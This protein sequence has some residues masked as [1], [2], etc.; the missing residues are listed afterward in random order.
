MSERAYIAVRQ[1]CDCVVA[2]MVDEPQYAKDNAKSLAD[3]VR[4]GYRILN[5]TPDEFRSR[6]FGYPCEHEIAAE[7]AAKS[8]VHTDQLEIGAA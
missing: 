1:N 6:P 7:A 4:R 8:G 3:L 2:V 5:V